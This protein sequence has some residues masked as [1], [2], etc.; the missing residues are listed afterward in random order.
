MP[1]SREIVDRFV[2]AMTDGDFD[3]QDE[4]LHDD[5]IVDFPQSGERI[6]GRANRRATMEDYPGGRIQQSLGRVVGG[7]DRWIASPAYRVVR[8]AGQGDELAV[9]GTVRYPNGD[10]W[11]TFELISLRDGRI[12][13]VTAYFGAPFDPPAWRSPYVER[14]P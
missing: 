14:I 4:L 5:V 1:N 2:R 8:V 3:A 6:R 9:V 7:E 10:V 12:A 11:H 13:H